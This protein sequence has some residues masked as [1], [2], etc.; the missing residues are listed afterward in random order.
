MM[1]ETITA[2]GVR[3]EFLDV[4]CADEDFVRAEFEAIIAAA[5]LTPPPVPPARRPATPPTSGVAP[6]LSWVPVSLE[7]AWCRRTGL[8]ETGR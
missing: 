8:A 2:S 6:V 4:L 3:D 7:R 1:G 5:W